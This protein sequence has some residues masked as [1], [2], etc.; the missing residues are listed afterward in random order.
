MKKELQWS[1]LKLNIDNG[2]SFMYIE[3]ADSYYIYCQNGTIV[4]WCELDKEDAIEFDASYKS[5]ASTDLNKNPAFKDKSINGKKL[6]KRIHG[7]S[8]TTVNGI[9][10]CELVVPYNNCKVN[11]IEI[12]GAEIGD[13]VQFKVK[14][15]DT[16]LLGTIPNSVLNQFGFDV[17]LTPAVHK[18][19]SEYDADLILN[20]K[21]VVEYHSTTVKDIY[22][23]YILH[24]VK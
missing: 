21:I 12:L 5:K 14:D 19:A 15:T 2:L 13:Y 10:S 8:Y 1:D 9:K 11:G 7:E 20:M 17:Y 22:I 23:N 16:G 4:L 6:F 18:E 3:K 24:E